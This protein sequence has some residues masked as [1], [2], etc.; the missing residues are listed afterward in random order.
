VELLQLADNVND[1]TV[2]EEEPVPQEPEEVQLTMD[3]YLANQGQGGTAARVTRKANDGDD[4][5][6][7]NARKHERPEL[8][9]DGAGVKVSMAVGCKANACRDWLSATARQGQDST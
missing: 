8:Q 7:A 6:F 3:E 1:V 9:E 5:Q 4:S 2:D